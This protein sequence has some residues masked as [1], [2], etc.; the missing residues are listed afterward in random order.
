M[1]CA[2]AL[3][4]QNATAMAAETKHRRERSPMIAPQNIGQ[5]KHKMA[6]SQSDQA[7]HFGAE[8]N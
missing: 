8:P 3:P 4:Q 2:A 7:N 6:I 5:A 1:F